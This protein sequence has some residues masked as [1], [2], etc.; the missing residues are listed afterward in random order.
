M[1]YHTFEFLRKRRKDPKWK[2]A[3]QTALLKRLWTLIAVLAVV[4]VIIYIYKNDVPYQEII[5]NISKKIMNF[6]KKGT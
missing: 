5:H 3:Y 1:A 6:I 2:D 4:V